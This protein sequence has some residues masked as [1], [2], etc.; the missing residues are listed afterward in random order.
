MCPRHQSY[1]NTD[2]AQASEKIST[3]VETTASDHQWNAVQRNHRK[4]KPPADNK[5][6]SETTATIVATCFSLGFTISPRRNQVGCTSVFAKFPYTRRT[7]RGFL[8]RIHANETERLGASDTSVR[9][10][11]LWLIFL[12]TSKFFTTPGAVVPANVCVK[13]ALI[14]LVGVVVAR[15]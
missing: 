14:W 8:L 6:V 10:L 9:S 7:A 12:S 11:C 3:M 15:I 13:N 1:P 2:S 4:N 5:M